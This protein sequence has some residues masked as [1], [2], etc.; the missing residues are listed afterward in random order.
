MQPHRAARLMSLVY[1]VR[2]GG[3]CFGIGGPSLVTCIGYVIIQLNTIQQSV[4]VFPGLPSEIRKR[5][6]ET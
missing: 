3:L 1:D 2:G 6:L 5:P 4:G